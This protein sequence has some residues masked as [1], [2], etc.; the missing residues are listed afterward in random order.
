MFLKL[1]LSIFN[2]QE[3][4]YRLARQKTKKANKTRENIIEKKWSKNTREE[5]K[6]CFHQG[7]LPAEGNN[8]RK[9]RDSIL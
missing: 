9:A 8:K 6:R 7:T 4:Q 1:L 3:S 2:V 5:N